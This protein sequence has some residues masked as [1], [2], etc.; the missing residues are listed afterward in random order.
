MLHIVPAPEHSTVASGAPT[1]MLQVAPLQSK[2][3]PATTVTLQADAPPHWRSQPCPHM[4]VHLVS[5]TVHSVRILA[6]L[7]TQA[8]LQMLAQAPVV[9]QGM[10]GAVVPL[11]PPSAV[12]PAPF[13]PLP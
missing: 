3:P 8:P 2:A 1:V 5:A 7:N 13:P 4:P 6:A 12:S 9:A 11:S 10:G